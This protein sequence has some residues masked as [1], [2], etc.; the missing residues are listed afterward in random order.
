MEINEYTHT[1]LAV[2]LMYGSY[3][4]GRYFRSRNIVENAINSCLI[5]LEKEGL[6]HT[7]LDKDGEKVW[8]GTYS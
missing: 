7:R 6:I 5:N 2:G 3:I 8:K 4:L 1:I